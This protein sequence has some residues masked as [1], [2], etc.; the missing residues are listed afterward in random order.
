MYPFSKNKERPPPKI[1]WRTI[2]KE[3]YARMFKNQLV[4]KMI[5][6]EDWKANLRMDVGKA[7]RNI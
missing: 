2:E 3:E 6:I 7:W 4:N 5:E 1:R